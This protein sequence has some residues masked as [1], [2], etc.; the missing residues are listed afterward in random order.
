MKFYISIEVPEK[1]LLRSVKDA[2]VS[3]FELKLGS[4]RPMVLHKLKRLTFGPK[5]TRNGFVNVRLWAGVESNKSPRELRAW[6]S[7]EKSY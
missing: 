1:R 7:N 6:H 3:L 4:K 2:V 5:W